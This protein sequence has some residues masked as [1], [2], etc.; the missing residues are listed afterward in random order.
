MRGSRPGTLLSSGR[1]GVA[2]N[3]THVLPICSHLNSSSDSW[4]PRTVT[5]FYK[6]T[7]VSAVL[8]AV[9]SCAL[10]TATV[11]YERSRKK[12]GKKFQPPMRGSRPGTLLSS[13]R[14]GVATNSTHVLPICSHLNS[15]S[16]SDGADGDDA[17]CRS[18]SSTTASKRASVTLLAILKRKLP[19]IHTS[20][21]L[22][23]LPFTSSQPADTM[24]KITCMAIVG[25][26]TRHRS[27]YFGCR[28]G[29]NVD[30]LDLLLHFDTHTELRR[31]WN[32][33]GMH[34]HVVCED[35]MLP[36]RTVTRPM[37]V[38]PQ[39]VPHLRVPSSTELTPI[40]SK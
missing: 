25:I 37:V 28:L 18:P 19:L 40:L 7:H 11:I 10:G 33:W 2:T 17:S 14:W 35:V 4:K 6:S 16:S 5:I 1:W 31:T 36:K 29:R 3:S 9:A 24:S 32:Q 13:G 27:R 23:S 22:P 34:I 26:V 20:L 39:K 15:R 30:L 8:H 12:F 21:S 38:P